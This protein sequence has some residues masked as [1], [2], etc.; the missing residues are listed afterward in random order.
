MIEDAG[1]DAIDVSIGVGGSQQLIIAPAVMP[2]GYQLTLS[3][4]IKKSVSVPVIA[5]GRI[6]EPIMAEDAILTGK[7]DLIAWGRS[8]LA[9]PDLP[10]KVSQNK[11]D[12]ICPCVGCIQGCIR[13]FPYPDKPPSKLG[14][15][16]L[17]NPFC[18]R[19]NE[20]KIEAADKKKKI[21][22]IGGGPGGLEAAWI[23]AARGHSVTLYEK[24][25]KLGGQYRIAAIPPFKQDIAKAINYYVHMCKKHGVEIKTGTEATADLIISGEPDAVIIATGSEPVIP[26]EKWLR[27]ERV[28]FVSDI[29]E[30]KKQTGS[31]VLIA[32]GGMIG[33]EVADFLGEHLHDVTV[34]EMLPEIARDMPLSSK[35]FLLKRFEEYSI[36]VENETKMISLTDTG[37]IV[38]KNGKHIH[39]EGF[40]TIVLALGNR[41]VN[42]LEKQL[43]EKVPELHVIGDALAP[44]MALQAIEEGARVAVGI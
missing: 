24:D 16:C 31:R 3:E 40:D 26:D 17:V 6:T 25:Q 44:R 1:I 4:E 15:T 27:D 35:Y 5:V 38:E 29:L 33:C 36:R 7:A 30:G 42:L 41:S 20:L 32:G 21:T 13:S 34:I 23:A 22:V 18:G 9:D 10:R 39:L 19:E 2:P 8:S 14:I 28:V 12:D 37:V 11:M 43:E